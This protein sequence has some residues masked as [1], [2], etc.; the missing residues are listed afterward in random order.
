MIEE[1]LLRE[2]RLQSA[3]LKAAFA[4]RIDALARKVDED[5]VARGIVEVLRE[6]GRTASGALK[7]ATA[8]RLPP[9]PMLPYAR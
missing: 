7:E 4:D 8:Q 3:I 6:R 1:D 9:V 5:P 2:T